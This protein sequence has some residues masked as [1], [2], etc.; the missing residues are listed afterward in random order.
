[1][2][3]HIF[4]RLL[5]SLFLAGAGGAIF[6]LLHLPIAWLLGSMT[7]VLIGSHFSKIALYWPVY[8]RDFG[9]LIVG[10]SLGLSFTKNALIQISH[11]LPSMLI[12]TVTIILFSAG[13]AYI[14][15][16]LTQISYQTILIGSIPGGL[17]QMILLAEEVKGVDITVVTFLQVARLT[18]IIFVVPFLVF[19]PLFSQEKMHVLESTS[20]LW[21]DLFPT[22][23]LFLVLSI[24]FSL[25]GK[26]IHMPTPFLL[27]PIIATAGLSLSGIHGPALPSTLLDLS[28]FMIGGHIGMM[29]K[30]ERLPNKGRTLLL[31]F[32]SGFFLIGGSLILSIF[33]IK[34]F[35]FSPSTSFLSLAPG[36]MDQMA[37][38]A[39][40]VDA[41]LSIVTGYQLF[42]LFFI[43]FIVPPLLKWLFKIKDRDKKQHS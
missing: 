34:I 23:L 29:M 26:R 20:P 43:F 33:L 4:K 21:H 15:S 17:S 41:D 19:G 25:L 28:Q 16:R 31:A 22:I 38:M 30:P 35:H 7:A 40:E 10:Y 39:H 9:I 14:V 18:M 36:G 13:T 37:I 42:R 32:L 1:M 27:G 8:L 12:V 24:V 5:L 2:N 6:H 11:K 3:Q